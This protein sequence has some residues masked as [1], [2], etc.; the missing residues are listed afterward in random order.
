MTVTLPKSPDAM[1]VKFPQWFVRSEGIQR[2]TGMGKKGRGLDEGSLNVC[3]GFSS[4]RR[5]WARFILRH[6]KEAPESFIH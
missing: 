1:A 4:K 2:R 3:I 5:I 6:Y